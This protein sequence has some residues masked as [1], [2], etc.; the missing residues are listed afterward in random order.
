MTTAFDLPDEMPAP[1]A[2]AW[3]E[4]LVLPL[5]GTLKPASLNELLGGKTQ[6]A[7]YAR[8]ALIKRWRAEAC[9]AATLAG[10]GQIVAGRPGHVLLDLSFPIHRGKRDEMNWV[11]M[12]KAATDG[13]VDAGCWPDDGAE[14]VITWGVTFHK[15][16]AGSDHRLIVAPRRYDCVHNDELAA[17]GE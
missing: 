4:P 9:A 10:A 13:L 3:T 16:P 17:L 15:R 12:L 14:F 1:A 5:R 6:Q 8:A 7:L 2:G 11:V